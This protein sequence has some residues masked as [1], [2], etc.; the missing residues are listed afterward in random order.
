MG[1][2]QFTPTISLVKLA[3]Q[4]EQNNLFLPKTIL[5]QNKS[6]CA[7]RF[8]FG[9]L[10]KEEL[11]IVILKLKEAYKNVVANILVD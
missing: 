7:I 11:E 9:H 3:E 10:N 4:A 1:V 2:L 8:G 5:Y 6:T